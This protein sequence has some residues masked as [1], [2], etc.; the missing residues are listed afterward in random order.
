MRLHLI[1][2]NPSLCRTDSPLWLDSRY[3]HLERFFHPKYQTFS[4]FPIPHL[5]VYFSSSTGDD[6]PVL[7]T[8]EKSRVAAGTRNVVVKGF[9]FLFVLKAFSAWY[10]FY[11]RLPK[12]THGSSNWKKHMKLCWSWLTSSKLEPPINCVT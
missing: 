6:I 4:D 10:L 11:C 1:F 3:I 5:L 12:I 9:H 7:R 8:P 2:F